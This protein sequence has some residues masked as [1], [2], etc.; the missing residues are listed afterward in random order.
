MPGRARSKVYG[1]KEV[2][3]K[4]ELLHLA[5]MDRE[6]RNVKGGYPD[7]GN[8]RFSTPEFINYQQWHQINRAQRIHKN[9]LEQLPT[10]V[11]LT[12]VSGLEFP[13][14][15]A[16]VSLL[17]GISR[18]LYMLPRRGAGFMLG[19]ASIALLAVGALYSS[20]KL[21]VEVSAL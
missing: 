6:L 3:V 19:L 20:V 13:F 17:F 7:H 21:I 15:T 2:E 12:L 14:A 8:G 4:I 10:V 1:S 9:F 16:I 18:F 5:E 11:V